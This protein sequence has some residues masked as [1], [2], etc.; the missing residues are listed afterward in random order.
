MYSVDFDFDCKS[1][2]GGFCGWLAVLKSKSFDD[3]KIANTQVSMTP[4]TNRF[5]NSCDDTSQDDEDYCYEDDLTAQPATNTSINDINIRAMSF[6]FS[7]D[8]TMSVL[9]AD[10]AIKKLFVT[11]NTTLPSSAPVECLLSSAGL[12][13][14]P[15]R[16]KMFEM[17]LMLKVNGF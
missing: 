5:I 3:G 2:F 4:I 12:I 1:Q 15:H 10:S 8:K 13:E 17:L 7:S 14:T 11:Y 6:L 16:N 9:M